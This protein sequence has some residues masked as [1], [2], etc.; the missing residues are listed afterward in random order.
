MNA[1]RKYAQ[2][3]TQTA[4]REQLMLM[5]FDAAL[6]HIRA[7]AEAADARDRDA[8]TRSLTRAAEIVTELNASLDHG[9]APELCRNLSRL[10]DFVT[11]RTLRAAA[12]LD[13][14]LAREAER[15][16]APIVEAFHQA[17]EKAGQRA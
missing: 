14:G 1:A 13:G 11:A 12:S 8:A 4:S 10:Y 3:Q 9:Q 5:L 15:A 17:V 2:T 7:G 16:F 6:R